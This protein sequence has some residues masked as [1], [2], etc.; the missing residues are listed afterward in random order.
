MLVQQI[1]VVAT[2]PF[3]SIFF[4]LLDAQGTCAVQAD[5][6]LLF[7]SHRYQ[8]R[9]RESTDQSRHGVLLSSRIRTLAVLPAERKRILPRTNRCVAK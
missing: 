7:K 1:T 2:T 8:R 3:I 6:G 9:P 5:Q 4:S